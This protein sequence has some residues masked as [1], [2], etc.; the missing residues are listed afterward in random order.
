M[1][2][3]KRHIF[4][5]ILLILL[6]LIVGFI[7]Y[8]QIATRI[9]PPDIKN[10]QALKQEVI[11]RTKDTRIINNHNWLRKS[12]SGL[13]EMRLQGQPFDLGVYNG[14][15]TE[16][17]IKIQ[18]LAFVEQI[19]KI[20]PSK[21]YLKFLKYF[22]GWFNR[23]ID[24]YIPQEY[25]DEIYG[26]SFS[27]SHEFDYI[28]PVYERM[29]NYHAAHDIGHALTDL[30]LVGCTSF[31][32][33][34]NGDSSNLLVGRNFDFY[35]NDDFAK[36]KIVVFVEPDSGYRFM[37][38]TWASMMGVVSGMNEQGLTVTI[39]AAK[40]NIPTK[41]AI[42]IS[43]LA[44]EILQY[45]SNFN[46]A[47]AIAKKRHTFV[48]ESL[49]IGSANNNSALIIE[50]S[51]TKM[52]IYTTGNDYLVCSNHYQSEPFARDKSNLENIANSA[53]FYR[54]E[55]CEQLITE[56]D[57]S[58]TY[59]D[60]AFVLRNPYGLNNQN[61]GIGNEKAMA[62]MISHHSVIFEPEKLIVWVSTQPWQL[63]EYVA[64]DL[65]KVFQLDT[66][67]GEDTYLNDT[68][69]T[70]PGDPFMQTS[71]FDDFMQYRK[72]KKVIAEYIKSKERINNE[73][74]FLND[75]VKLNP[76]YYYAYML[77]GDYYSIIG[78]SEK[79]LAYYR[80]ALTKELETK[81][82][83]TELRERIKEAE[84]AIAY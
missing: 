75:F 25:L 54:E 18:E 66:V 2:R 38:V 11:Q 62:Q 14:K 10:K 28:S 33:N 26:I 55:R 74:N 61:I 17:L 78:N 51:P 44:R 81:Q 65:K 39:N 58:F 16:D 19:N 53:S 67:P 41:A 43:I 34:M 48:S 6:L 64:Y 80:I 84:E 21:N 12:K 36:N 68:S 13:W 30:A 29:L 5:R 69:L 70:L 77:T 71:T 23:D 57:S 82:N 72:W 50:K 56:V 59:R 52:G 1:K 79:A 22:I 76:E 20:V 9:L 63:G 45:A 37:Y 32:V 31:A 3:K 42:P 46:E 8:Y 35:I 7:V 49:L 24:T 40:S 47:I 27:C 15:L 73:E 4:R 60:A 83:E